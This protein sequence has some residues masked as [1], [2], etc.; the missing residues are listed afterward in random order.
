VH[1][2]GSLINKMP[3]DA[4]Q[5]AANLRLALA[6]M[7]SHPGKKLLF[8]GSEIGQYEEWNAEGTVRW[9]LLQY[10]YHRR[11]QLLS[12]ELNRFY[13]EHPALYEVDFHHSGFEWVDIHDVQASVISF[14]RYSKDR[15]DELLFC[16]NFTPVVRRGYRLGVNETGFYEELFNSDASMFG[17]SNVGN[18]GGVEAEAFKCHGRA[19]SIS[20]TIPP[21]AV[22]A[23]RRRA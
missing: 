1:G 9:D 10:D 16:C 21:L 12:R 14:L 20:I 23:F 22:V 15:K 18:G 19:A 2:K 5:K 3:G 4:W 13:R 7:W 11:L 6:A 17:G 8:M